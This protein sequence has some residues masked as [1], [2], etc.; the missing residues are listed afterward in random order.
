MF[1]HLCYQEMSLSLENEG[2]VGDQ[3]IVVERCLVFLCI[4]H[5]CMAMGR[6][7]VAFIEGPRGRRHGRA[8]RAIPG[9]HG[10]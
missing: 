5:C 1:A 8:M 2:C 6:L 9:T 4:L 3:H 7:Q 10:C